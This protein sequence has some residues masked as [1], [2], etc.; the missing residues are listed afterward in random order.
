MQE[1]VLRFDLS[2]FGSEDLML[3]QWPPDKWIELWCGQ[4]SDF[5]ITLNNFGIVFSIYYKLV[6]C[7][8]FCSGL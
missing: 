8:T 2:N 7:L 3:G 4:I 5:P 1:I 6:P